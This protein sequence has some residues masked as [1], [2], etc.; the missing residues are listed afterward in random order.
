MAIN[1]NIEMS[2]PFNPIELREAWLKLAAAL[3]RHH[4]DGV[5]VADC[6]RE[7][8]KSVFYPR[9]VPEISIAAREVRQKVMEARRDAHEKSIAFR[10]AAAEEAL[11]KSRAREAM[12]IEKNASNENS[13]KCLKILANA[14]LP[15]NR[16][17]WS[18]RQINETVSFLTG[19][20][21]DVILSDNRTREVVPTRQAAFY[22][23]VKK[24]HISL[25]EIGKHMGKDHTSVLHGAR[26]HCA[27]HGVP[28][29]RDTSDGPKGTVYF[30]HSNR[31]TGKLVA[32]TREGSKAW[33]QAN[34]L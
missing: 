34:G 10:K 25:P 15:A 29:P 9:Q 31:K 28:Y 1:E 20:P 24:L 5:P 12:R 19:I 32:T 30:I 26:K 2:P 11:K 22:Y 16:R 7:T 23:C 6:R 3:V 21:V 13:I 8:G 18:V 14:P 27:T 33:R 17:R 4:G